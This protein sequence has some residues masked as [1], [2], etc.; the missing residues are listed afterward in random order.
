LHG[1]HHHLDIMSRQGLLDA[2]YLGT[3]MELSTFLIGRF[4]SG[5]A[6]SEEIAEFT[7]TTSMWLR[8]KRQFSIFQRLVK[9]DGS[10]CRPDV[11]LF[12]P[13]F[14]HLSVA[15]IRYKEDMDNV[16]NS[17]TLQQLRKGISGCIKHFYPDLVAPFAA[18]LANKAASPSLAWD[19]PSFR[20]V[21]YAASDPTPGPSKRT[22]ETIDI[23]LEPQPWAK[24]L[25]VLPG[26][27]PLLCWDGY[28]LNTLGS[29]HVAS[30]YL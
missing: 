22:K 9:D 15:I 27:F 23:D 10:Q 28:E 29:E 16:D 5:Q 24:R 18:L 12:S 11:A 19:A 8:F 25:K 13:V 7:E 17:F 6:T 14:L 30:W 20:V 1:C 3:F 2:T 21:D 26:V 4:Y